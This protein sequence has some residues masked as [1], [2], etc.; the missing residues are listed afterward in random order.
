MRAS[1]CTNLRVDESSRHTTTLYG[2]ECKKRY[3][4]GTISAQ[5]IFDN[6]GTTTSLG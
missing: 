3:G 6:Q 5:D 1:T 2:A 4:Y